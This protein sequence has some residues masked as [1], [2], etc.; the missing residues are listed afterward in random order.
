MYSEHQPEG[1][2]EDALPPEARPYQRWYDKDPVLSRALEQL[3]NAP[4][5]Y[6]AQIALNI[7][8]II[9]E[10]R[11]EEETEI[12]AGELD[13]SLPYKQPWGNNQ[14]RRWY[15]VHETLRSAMQLLHDCPDDLQTRI[16]PSIATMIEA[17]LEEHRELS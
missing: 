12:Q 7:I 17:T 3:R 6:Q 2:P 11:I 4:D 1:N 10:H 13:E 5:K 8:K 16:I 9:V 15:D 14:N